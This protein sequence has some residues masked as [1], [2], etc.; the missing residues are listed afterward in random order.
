M[1]VCQV[2]VIGLVIVLFNLL[3]EYVL[4]M[5]NVIKICVVF[6]IQHIV[7]NIH[8]RLQFQQTDNVTKIHGNNVNL[9]VHAFKL[10]ENFFQNAL[11]NIVY[12]E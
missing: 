9:E 3:M 7:N 11:I 12:L 2:C 6:K 1:I 10:L 4:I 8:A 5:V